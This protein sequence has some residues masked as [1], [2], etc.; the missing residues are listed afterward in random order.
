MTNG[1]EKSPQKVIYSSSRERRIDEEAS[2]N[3]FSGRADE[4]LQWK[5]EIDEN[6][7]S[8]PARWE[9]NGEE[10]ESKERRF[11]DPWI[12]EAVLDIRGGGPSSRKSGV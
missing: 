4:K 9:E 10:V 2:S 7:R 1:S 3:L 11:R 5:A 6:R 8:N 12:G